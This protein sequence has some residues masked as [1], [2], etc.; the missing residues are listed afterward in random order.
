MPTVAAFQYNCNAKAA[1][2]PHA[3]TDKVCY[4]ID[5][6]V[7]TLMIGTR[8]AGIEIKTGNGPVTVTE[9]YRYSKGKPAT[10]HQ[11]EGTTLRLT[12]S[13]CGD[14]DARC[15]VRYRIRVPATTS[16][17]VTAQAGAVD[18]DGLAWSMHISTEAGAVEGRALT[19]RPGIGSRPSIPRHR[20][21]PVDR[22]L[23][24][25]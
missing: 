19:G 12:E 9:E 6:Q 11:V 2:L 13:G 8:A 17:E 14:D 7:T 23:L 22:G 20:H 21:P 24:R 16:V 10:A 5:E 25:A 15:E 1:P 4:Q 3:T 18:V